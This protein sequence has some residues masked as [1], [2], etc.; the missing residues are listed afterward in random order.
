MLERSAEL[1]GPNLGAKV[2]REASMA[3]GADT[4]G[5][6]QP[7]AI[8]GPGGPPAGAPQSAQR[9][10]SAI[11]L[12]PLLSPEPPGLQGQQQAGLLFGG[13]AGRFDH[14]ADFGKDASHFILKSSIAINH[15]NDSRRCVD[16]S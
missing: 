6:L 11:A 13:Q 9:G 1:L 12:L 2:R 8:G 10:G 5:I 7:P 15:I 3:D 4:A 14:G 16:G